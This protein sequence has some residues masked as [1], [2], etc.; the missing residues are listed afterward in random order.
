MKFWGGSTAENNDNVTYVS[1]NKS[2]QTSFYGSIPPGS[3]HTAKAIEIAATTHSGRPMQQ[4]APQPV[5]QGADSRR[6]IQMGPHQEPEA[7]SGQG[8][9][10]GTGGYFSGQQAPQQQPITKRPSPSSY[11][12]A[13][14]ARV[15]QTVSTATAAP[16][17]YRYENGQQV[18]YHTQNANAELYVAAPKGTAEAQFFDEIASRMTNGSVV[19]ATIS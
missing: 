12:Q 6:M 13:D 18:V 5:I 2:N 11:H 14:T 8:G 7:A 17:A 16:V 9:W 15:P 3:R 4:N 19:S 1:S 10:F